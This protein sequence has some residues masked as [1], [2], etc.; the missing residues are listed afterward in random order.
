MTQPLP[1]ISPLETHLG[2]WMRFISNQVSGNFQKLLQQHDMSVA[3]WVL[4]RTLY[5][6]DGVSHAELQFTLGM[7]KGATSKIVSRLENKSLVERHQ[8]E[9][10]TRD[11]LMTLTAR[12]NQLLPVL[13]ELADKNDELFFGHLPKKMRSELTALL[14]TLGLHHQLKGVPD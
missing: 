14:K 6:R 9:P 12:G 1:D 2:F 13:A 5:Q 8:A 11:Q 10:G 7:T 4:M 3:E